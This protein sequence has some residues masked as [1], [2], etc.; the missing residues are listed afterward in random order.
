MIR[1]FHDDDRGLAV[2]IVM[3]VAIVVITAFLIMFLTPA[4]NQVGGEML[5]NTDSQVAK[6]AINLRMRIW[7]LVGF[8][9]LFAGAFFII[10]RGVT[11]G[12]A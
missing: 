9:G 7:G 5:T 10:R 2:G 4:F 12:R 6:D 3:F 11:E 1:R 8:F